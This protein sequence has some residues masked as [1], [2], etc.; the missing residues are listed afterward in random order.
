MTSQAVHAPGTTAGDALDDNRWTQ[1]RPGPFGVLLTATAPGTPVTAVPVPRLRHLA[2][3]HH[4]VALRGFTAPADAAA[5][6]A[7]ART[8]GEVME[9]PFGTV[10]DVRAHQ[11][12]EDHVFDTGFMPLHWDGMYVD[13]VPE[14]QI[15]HCVAAPGPAEG[16]GTLF[17]DTTRVLADAA[18]ET[19]ERWRGLTLRY[20]NAKV[21][22]YGGLVVS[23]LIEPHPD[24]G[25]PVMR[26]LEPVPD[27]EHIV[28]EPTVRI[29]GLEGEAAAAEL[30]A[31]REAAYDPRHRHT[32][33]WQ[34][35]DV[36][37]ADNYTLLHTREPYRRGLPR[38]LRRVHVLGDPPLPSHIHDHHG[39][40]GA[41]DRRGTA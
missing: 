23:P 30:A 4:L 38:H 6:D 16:G 14:F 28:N 17:C 31:I 27:G 8:W 2:R 25:F 13:H 21:S 36:V 29:D 40:T 7:Y 18:P 19:L 34:R 1:S 22:H 37:I 26:F 41:G 33:A 39:A 5:L 11:D 35:D 24:A 32:H 9:W 20:R 3:R 12:P 15:F 10:F